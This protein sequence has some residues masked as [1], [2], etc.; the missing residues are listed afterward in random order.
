MDA[1]ARHRCGLYSD[2]WASTA[3]GLA[4][5]TPGDQNAKQQPS[6]KERAILQSKAKLAAGLQLATLRHFE[7]FHQYVP[8]Q[9]KGSLTWP[10]ICLCGAL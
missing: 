6:S 5:A 9:R 7:I 2:D 8:S 1:A 3:I 10:K 4:S